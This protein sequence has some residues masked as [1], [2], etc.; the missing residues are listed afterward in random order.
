MKYEHA[1][2][3][4]F[5]EK[6]SGIQDE[7]NWV[8]DHN[9]DWKT[10]NLGSFWDAIGEESIVEEKRI[11]QNRKKYYKDMPFDQQLWQPFLVTYYSILDWS[12]RIPRSGIKPKF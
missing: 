6:F 12:K 1:R 11:Y 9:F 5:L 3:I 4:S 8:F 10:V 2:W 7:V